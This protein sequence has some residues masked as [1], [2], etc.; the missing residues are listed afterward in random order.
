VLRD[1]LYGVD[2]NP[3]LVAWCHANIPF[4]TVTQSRFSP[5][6]DFADGTFGLVYC[7]SVF[8]HLS[9]AVCRQW[10]AEMR[11]ILRP[12]GAL[13][14][15]FH[16][17]WYRGEVAKIGPEALERLDRDGILYHLFGEGAAEG[18]NRYATFMTRGY[19]ER[20]FDGFKAVRW[21]SGEQ[22]THF[23]ADQDVIVL[24]RE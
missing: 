9:P 4:A 13:A 17:D 1:V 18:S 5:P 8:T 20:L 14:V 22:P 23:A 16:G 2:V 21:F 3:A 12:G 24:L 7:V 11:R 10:A 15:S 19:I 6:L